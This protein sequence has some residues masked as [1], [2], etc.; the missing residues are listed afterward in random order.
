MQNNV[1]RK[2]VKH[3][4]NGEADKVRLL[5]TTFTPNADLCR[6]KSVPLQLLKWVF[7]ILNNVAVFIR[8]HYT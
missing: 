7:F 8:F 5:W 1:G 2:E 4:G 6:A 3:L